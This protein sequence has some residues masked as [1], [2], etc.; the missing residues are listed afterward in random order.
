M[1]EKLEE[2]KQLGNYI[3]LQYGEGKSCNDTLDKIDER[4]IRLCLFPFGYLNEL[5]II[6][7]GKY[8]DFLRFDFTQKANQ[9]SNPPLLEEIKNDGFFVSGTKRALEV[10]YGW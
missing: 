5:K 9:V 7:V 10:Y 8:K 1:I 2:I 3:Q 6:W 4:C